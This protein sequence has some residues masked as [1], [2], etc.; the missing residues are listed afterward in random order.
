[1]AKNV[2]NDPKFGQQTHVWSPGSIRTLNRSPE[3]FGLD[4]FF[5]RTL[6]SPFGDNI[7]TPLKEISFNLSLSPSSNPYGGSVK[8]RFPLES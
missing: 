4:R 2:P 1:M 8:K 7:Y 3:P 6:I 5:I